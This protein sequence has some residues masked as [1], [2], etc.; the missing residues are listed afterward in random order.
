MKK[1]TILL[2]ILGVSLSCIDN[3]RYFTELTPFQQELNSE[4]KDVT[5]SPLKAVDRSS[6]KSLDFYEYDSLY[7]VKARFKKLN[8]ELVF[9]M[10]TTTDRLPEY[11]KYGEIDF[12]INNKSFQ[13]NLYQNQ[14]L[15]KTEGYEKY[16]FLPFLDDTNGVTTYSG[17]RYIDLEIPTDSLISID[18]NNAYNPYCAYNEKY[19]CPIVPRENYLAL[20][21]S[22]GV[23]SFQTNK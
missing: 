6:F 18:F 19:S 2:F 15:I 20:E 22:A 17:G 13:L 5:S 12:K 10:V 8:N 9:N 7:L 23:K 21:I 16:L 14:E 1:L 3:K 11:I 4:F